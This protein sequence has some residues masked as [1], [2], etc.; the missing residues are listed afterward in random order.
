MPQNAENSNKP[1]S[2]RLVIRINNIE[3]APDDTIT[4][5][6][7]ITGYGYIRGAKVAIYPPPYL[8]DTKWAT[9][10]HSMD[11]SPDGK[12]TWG[13]VED[14]FDAE[15]GIVLMLSA[16]LKGPS[17]P[18]PSQFFDAVYGPNGPKAIYQIASE[19]HLGKAPVE[20]TL[21][22]QKK[23]PTGTHQLHFYL[24][25]FNGQQWCTDSKSI[26]L[27]APTFFKRHEGL[28]WTVG[29]IIG[30]L[31]FLVTVAAALKTLID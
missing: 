18:S 8:I 24:T 16:G 20:F 28:I 29:V 23:I 9:V 7:Y 19:L 27:V 15:Y 1:G 6:L 4:V 3:I 2:Y 12:W 22:T 30:I 5:E 26:N 11:L 31:P 17:W 25:Y 14:E 21:Q 10:T 13:A